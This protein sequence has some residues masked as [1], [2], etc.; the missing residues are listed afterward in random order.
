MM[1]P[2][3]LDEENEDETRPSGGKQ[4]RVTRAL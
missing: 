4:R 3:N 2:V 1:K